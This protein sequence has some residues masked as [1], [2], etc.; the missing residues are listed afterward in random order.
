MAIPR[1]W[2]IDAG[3]SFRQSLAIILALDLFH[4]AV[5][6]TEWYRLRSSGRL[7]SPP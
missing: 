6:L 3:G 2:G 5:C 1:P 4:L 7:R